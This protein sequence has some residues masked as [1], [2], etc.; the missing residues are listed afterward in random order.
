MGDLLLADSFFDEAFGEF[1]KGLALMPA[2]PSL[3]RAILLDGIAYCHFVRG[4]PRA[5]FRSAFTSLRMLRRLDARPWERAP[6]VTLCFGYLEVGRFRDAA[7]HGAIALRLAE[8]A[9]DEHNVKNALYLLGEAANLSGDPEGAY[10]HFEA[11]QR[12]FFP[13]EGYLPNFL[14][15]VDVRRLINLKA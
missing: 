4:D 5:G 9:H 14:L 1:E 10:R 11:L 2:D 12:R 6:R 7:R 15:A 3:P 13:G 8:R